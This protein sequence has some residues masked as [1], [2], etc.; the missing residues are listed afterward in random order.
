MRTQNTKHTNYETYMREVTK[1]SK[2]WK[3]LIV[4]LLQ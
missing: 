1:I 4:V 2:S 3:K